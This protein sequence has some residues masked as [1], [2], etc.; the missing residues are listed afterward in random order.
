MAAVY[1]LTRCLFFGGRSP[2]R[3]TTP[4]GGQLRA[5]EKAKEEKQ[6]RGGIETGHPAG[7]A[8][9]SSTTSTSCTRP[10]YPAIE[11]GDHTRTRAT[12]PRTEG[13]CERFHRTMPE[14]FYHVA[15]REKV[16]ES[17]QTS[18]SDVDEPWTR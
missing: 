10:L 5:L 13:I 17:L 4:G 8:A 14:E 9:T 12:S 15:F 18:Q 2:D 1:C 16:Y 7:Y 11:D 3:G 6:A